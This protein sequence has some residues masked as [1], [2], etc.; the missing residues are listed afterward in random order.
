MVQS[1]FFIS[2]RDAALL[3][4]NFPCFVQSSEFGPGQSLVRVL[5][6][7]Q[8]VLFSSQPKILFIAGAAPCSRIRLQESSAR[9]KC[10]C[11]GGRGNALC[12]GEC[13]ARE[14]PSQSTVGSSRFQ[15]QQFSL[16]SKVSIEGQAGVLVNAKFKN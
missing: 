2:Y 11:Q 8:Q 12:F 14:R 13:S 7:S 4:S 15:R 10:C 6:S 3:Y 9:C 1:S 5:I 16:R